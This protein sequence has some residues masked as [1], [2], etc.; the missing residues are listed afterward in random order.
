M[1]IRNTKRAVAAVAL[2]ALATYPA[3]VRAD[4]TAAEIRL[5]KARL[6]Q[7]EEKVAK[8]DRKQREALAQVPIAP[9]P[10][11]MVC[12]DAPCPP[13]PP[14]VFVSFANG[15][16]VESFDH[17]FS[18]KIGGRIF[19]DGGVNSQP[20]QTFVGV[21]PFFPAHG[22]TGFGNQVGFR[23]A[24]LEVE[25]RAWKEWLYKLQYDFTGAP[26][27]L[28][29]GGIRDFWLAWQPQFL[30]PIAPVTIQVGNQFEASSMERMAS[31]KYRDFIER[32]LPS[33]LLAG[34]R[35]VGLAIETGGDDVWGFYGKP[36]WSLK[37]GLYSTSFEDGNPFPGAV[38]G[39]VTNVNFGLPAGNSNLLNPVPG[40]KQYWDAAARLTYAPIRDPEHLLHLGGWVRYQQPNDAT[41]ANDNRV[42][43]PGSTLASEAN[44]LG[45]SLLGTQPLTCWNFPTPFTPALPVNQTQLVG[46]NCVKN[47]LNY[48]AE[49]EAAWGPFSL[50][51][52][53]LGMHYNRDPGIIFWQNTT[54]GGTRPAGGA[55]INF[56]G[57]Y[58]YATWYL[59]GES[60][61]EQYR[62]Y[63]EFNAPGNGN[64]AQ[65]KIL[66]P[67]RAGGWGAWE[68]AARVSEINLND[69]GFLFLQPFGTRSNIQGGRQS[70]FT[71]GLNW[72]PDKGIR[73]MANWVNVFQFSA[74]F[75]RPDL[76]GIHPNLFVL[77]AQVDW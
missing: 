41:A 70:D 13:P 44:I 56:D 34:N 52:E 73:F 29:Q 18:F 74:P 2:G 62:S 72:Y 3:A 71:L 37:G 36:T 1:K 45:E 76:D 57:F 32:A 10:P 46:L 20:I 40:G 50:Q 28:V 64:V 61:A 24:R 7:L 16:K 68:L 63:E 25:G 22:A 15:L 43:Q 38:A 48:G 53:Y 8:Q 27:G 54:A 33:D 19:V 55:T 66:N 77:R 23:Q 35:H 39:A 26:N 49:L 31:S 9:P 47:V 75:N 11:G 14:P 59:T 17:D 30:Q 12:K 42:L 6:K 5:L 60:R 67:W 69:G 51:A 65:I 4:D 21:P 58:A